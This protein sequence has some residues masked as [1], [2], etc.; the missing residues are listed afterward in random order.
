MYGIGTFNRT[1][2]SS[3]AS[4]CHVSSR[5]PQFE[6]NRLHNTIATIVKMRK[7]PLTSEN[8]SA[9][10]FTIRCSFFR[11]YGCSSSALVLKL[12][13]LHTLSR[14]RKRKMCKQV[15]CPNDGKPTW[16]GCGASH[17]FLSPLQF[18]P[19]LTYKHRPIHRMLTKKRILK[20]ANT[21]NKPSPPFPLLIDATVLT[22]LLAFR[23]CMKLRK[24]GLL[25]RCS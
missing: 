17:Y 22:C 25:R 12:L 19:T 9:S 3:V 5:V 14:K 23:E 21:S 18:L 4:K 13:P 10:R 16:W 6:E 1:S 7:M 24:T 2:E 8:S 20:K 15:T 11:S